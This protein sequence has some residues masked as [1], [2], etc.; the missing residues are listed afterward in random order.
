MYHLTRSFYRRLVVRGLAALFMLGTLGSALRAEEEP[1]LIPSGASFSQ[2]SAVLN[3][4]THPAIR[5]DLKLNEDQ[6]KRIQELSSSLQGMTLAVD[7]AT[8]QSNFEELADEAQR[9]QA[10]LME[11][12]TP[13]QVRRHCQLALQ[14]VLITSGLSE[15]VAIPE[16]STLLQLD[17]DQ[18]QQIEDAKNAQLTAA[19]QSLE[20]RFA[21]AQQRS[22]G[23]FTNPDLNRFV[24]RSQSIELDERRN[25]Q[26]SALLTMVQKRRLLETLGLPLPTHLPTLAMS[27]RQAAAPPFAGGRGGFGARGGRG[28]RGAPVVLGGF[29]GGFPSFQT[30]RLSAQRIPARWNGL[31]RIAFS[32]F[33]MGLG[34][35]VQESVLEELKL[36]A[37]QVQQHVPFGGDSEE[38]LRTVRQLDQW[39]SPAQLSRLRQLVLQFSIQRN[40]PAAIFEFTDVVDVLQLSGPQR[41]ALAERARTDRHSTRHL[42]LQAIE[43]EP[44]KLA[45]MEKEAFQELQALLTVPQREQVAKLIGEPFHGKLSAVTIEQAL[46]SRRSTRARTAPSLGYLTE[47][48]VSYLSQAAIRNEL[49]LSEEQRAA[50]PETGRFGRGGRGGRGGFPVGAAAGTVATAVRALDPKMLE[51][52]GDA[53]LQRYRGILLQGYVRSDGPATIFRHKFVLDALSLTD[54]QKQGLL[55]IVREDTRAYLQISLADLIERQPALDE[56]TAGRLEAVLTDDQRGKL[57][58][59]LGEPADCLNQPDQSEP[60]F[61][62]AA[63]GR[64]RRGNN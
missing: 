21:S 13:A 23:L 51:L 37:E 34:L 17:A 6:Q 28:G 46:E 4:V 47:I 59:L 62:P 38:L 44:T 2:P 10:A 16:M 40:G 60:G 48:P 15:V 3:Y 33:V 11:I 18:A 25:D 56:K 61:L 42:V 19:Q 26:L 12:L 22:T 39:L 29:A 1:R 55:R 24:S 63:G 49:Q 8:R 14:R 30:S 27:F 57:A 20:E 9:T 45:E 43:R 7:P 64:G 5:D 32:E 35:L 50:I 41:T 52:L 31:G 36:T 58:K 53:Q 54:D